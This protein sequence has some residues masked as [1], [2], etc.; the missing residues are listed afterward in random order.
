VAYKV[1]VTVLRIVIFLK[2]WVLSSEYY[3]VLSVPFIVS[4][5]TAAFAG[6]PGGLGFLS[7]KLTVLEDSTKRTAVDREGKQLK[8]CVY[9]VLTR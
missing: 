6:I 3:I 4:L 5:G 2:A 9:H 1:K 7:N 8:M